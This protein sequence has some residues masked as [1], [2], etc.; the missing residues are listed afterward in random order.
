MSVWVAVVMRNPYWSAGAGSL[1]TVT[2]TVAT[3][4]E[5]S[6]LNLKVRPECHLI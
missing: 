3:K 4:Q 1:S 5:W 2:V 6:V